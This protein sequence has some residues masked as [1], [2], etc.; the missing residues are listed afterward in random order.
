[1][2]TGLYQYPGYIEKSMTNWCRVYAKLRIFKR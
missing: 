1:M 2:T